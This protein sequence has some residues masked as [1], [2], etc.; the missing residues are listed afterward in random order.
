MWTV[1]SRRGERAATLLSPNSKECI[2]AVESTFSSS[3]LRRQSNWSQTISS[4]TSSRNL[5]KSIVNDRLLDWDEVNYA[6]FWYAVISVLCCSWLFHDY[7]MFKE[8]DR[9]LFVHTQCTLGIVEFVR[10][11]YS[12]SSY[13]SLT[14][15]YFAFL[16]TI[17]VT[18]SLQTTVD[19]P[20]HA[21]RR[22][23]RNVPDHRDD[24]HGTAQDS[25]ARP[26]TDNQ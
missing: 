13:R 21:C 11:A 6:D 1:P 3:L 5:M 25:D 2:R 4:D 17:K 23:G 14:M 8:W 18:A 12:V 7:V 26:G 20:R 24:S 15:R 22:S 19:S 10:I 16:C 9:R